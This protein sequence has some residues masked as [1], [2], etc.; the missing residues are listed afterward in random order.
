MRIYTSIHI[1]SCLFASSV[2]ASW[3]G[4]PPSG[5]FLPRPTNLHNSSIIHN[6]TSAFDKSLQ[7]ALNGSIS[8][9][10]SVA[11]TSF[12]LGLVSLDS[13]KPLWSYHYRGSANINGTATI[14]NDTQ[15]LIG[16]ISKL[17][18]DLLVLRTGIDLDTPITNYLPSLANETSV[19][20]WE[21]VTLAALA[22]HLAGIPPNYGFSDFYI[23][24]PFLEE[25][26]F[27]AIEASEYAS[28]GVTGLNKGCSQEGNYHKHLISASFCLQDRY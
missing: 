22:D 26:G 8:P 21:E 13:P 3:S 14:D 9:G 1:S 27:P 15:Y 17:I 23:L 10:F 5:P 4:C 6:A 19:I 7:S 11:N 24:Q 2:H 20:K 16:S 12:S 25:L 28:C 18:T